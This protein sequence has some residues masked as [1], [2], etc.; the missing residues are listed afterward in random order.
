MDEL[1]KLLAD[2]G[3]AA[4]AAEEALDEGAHGTAR[5][6]LD[7][8]GDALAELRSRWPSMSAAERGVVGKAAA[9]V[10]SRLDAAERRLPRRSA[11]TQVAAEEDPEQDADPDAA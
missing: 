4:T 10:K 8:G 1:L 7:R 6:E 11:L 2:A 9:G 5:E 3:L